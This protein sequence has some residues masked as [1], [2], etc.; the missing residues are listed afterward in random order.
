[1]DTE[2]DIGIIDIE[3]LLSKCRLC[4]R[5]FEEDRKFCPLDENVKQKFFS[6]TQMKVRVFVSFL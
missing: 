3:E 5:S 4:F 2:V 1:M 6:L